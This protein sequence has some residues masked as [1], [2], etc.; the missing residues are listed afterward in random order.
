MVD[1]NVRVYEGVLE[2]F[3]EVDNLMFMVCI[4]CV[5]LLEFQVKI[6]V[7]FEWYNLFGLVKDCVVY[8]LFFDV[9]EK[10]F[11]VEG[12]KFVEL[13]SGNMGMGFVM[14]VNVNGFELMMLFF[15]KI[16]FEKCVMFK[17]FGINVEEFE[18]DL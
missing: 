10:G 15:N 3:F 8:N 2:M 7:K 11:F 12:Q 6:Y 17:V 13:M 1:Q 16:L 9:G 18:D 4:N 14:M 5:V